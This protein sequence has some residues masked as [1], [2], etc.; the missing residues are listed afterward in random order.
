[1]SAMAFD[2]RARI[3]CRLL[4]DLK[5][6]EGACCPQESWF[7]SEEGDAF[8]ISLCVFDETFGDFADIFHG[9]DRRSSHD[10]RAAGVDVRDSRIVFE[11]ILKVGLDDLEGRRV[12]SVLAKQFEKA[13]A[14]RVQ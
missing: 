11:P 2:P 1:M 13:V 7:D 4:A 8:P 14:H 5:R 9:R 6:G 10:P 3:P 12:P